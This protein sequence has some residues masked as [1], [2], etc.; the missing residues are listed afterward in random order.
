MR[1]KRRKLDD[2]TETIAQ[3]MA[4]VRTEVCKMTQREFADK[5]GISQTH[6]ISDYETGITRPGMKRCHHIINMCGELGVQVT[7]SW[8]R[9]DETTG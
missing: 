2:Y 8:L 5:L 1:K 3:R 4:W 9:P 6:T 7:Y